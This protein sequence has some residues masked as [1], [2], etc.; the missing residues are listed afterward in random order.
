MK[1]SVCPACASCLLLTH[2]SWRFNVLSHLIP[3]R[4]KFDPVA[5]GG[6]CAHYGTGIQYE[7][8]YSEQRDVVAAGALPV[9]CEGCEIMRRSVLLLVLLVGLLA[10]GG[11][12]AAQDMP[13]PPGEVVID[14]LL[15]PRGISFG[16]DGSLVVVEGG[17]GGDLLVAETP[18]GNLM[19][20]LDWAVNSVAADGTKTPLLL[21]PSL[22]TG[23]EAI[24]A[25]RAYWHDDSWWVVMTGGAPEQP[26]WNPLSATILQLDSAGRILTVI[27]TWP[28][29][30]ANNPDGLEINTN[31]SD[32]AWLSDGTLL[33]TDAGGNAL[34]SWTAA[35]GLQLVH[36]W[37]NDVPTS[38]EVTAN[39]DVYVGFLGEGIAPGAGRIEHWS[40]GDLVETFS[41]LTG[42]TDI[43]VTADGTL[44]AVQLFQAGAD[45]AAP[46]GPGNIVTVTA[47]GATPVVEGLVLPHSM[48]IGDDGSIYVTVGTA[49]FFGP[50][51]GQVLKIAGM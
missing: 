15:Q 13:P 17:D 33:I 35:D 37:G 42:V 39:D 30:E 40:G 32:I 45:P 25:Y 49:A 43:E 26:P 8:R 50:V 10:L 19:A 34:L 3:G 41:G 11:A 27:D 47:D 7:M 20:G 22:N 51:P 9:E 46:P 5:L 24:S 16:P 14:G 36:A 48:A 18:D 38:V 31:P 6:S 4:A 28:F 2:A 1:T 12:V 44:Y 29:E 21:L 23:T